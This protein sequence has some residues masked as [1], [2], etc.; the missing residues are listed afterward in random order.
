M[1]LRYIGSFLGGKLYKGEGG[2]S[3]TD[4]LRELDRK[5]TTDYPGE[6]L[7]LLFEDGHGQI[8]EVGDSVDV[9]ELIDWVKKYGVASRTC[10]GNTR[11]AR[12]EAYEECA[13]ILCG[14]YARVERP[15]L[16]GA[17]IILMDESG[18]RNG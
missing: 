6:T 1:G 9:T 18:K 5:R 13:D 8:L 7:Y 15:T 4:L 12:I 17:A 2:D 11:H 10:V 14:L 3:V 16:Y